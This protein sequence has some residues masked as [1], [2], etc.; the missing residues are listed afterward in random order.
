LKLSLMQLASDSH[1]L[2]TSSW[3]LASYQG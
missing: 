3:V 2:P 1:Q